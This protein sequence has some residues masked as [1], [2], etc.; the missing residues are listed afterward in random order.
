MIIRIAASVSHDVQVIF[1]PRGARMVR[2]LPLCTSFIVIP[3]Y[4]GG[5]VWRSQAV[6]F[7]AA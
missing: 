4:S 7:R 2:D 1:A 3:S 5:T 6:V